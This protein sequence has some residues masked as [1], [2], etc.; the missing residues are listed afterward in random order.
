MTEARRRLGTVL[1]HVEQA[2]LPAVQLWAILESSVR[3]RLSRLILGSAA[4]TPP[5]R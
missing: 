3:L 1:R 5:S 4:G 2:H